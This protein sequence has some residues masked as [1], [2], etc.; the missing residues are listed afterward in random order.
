MSLDPLL[1]RDPFDQRLSE[2]GPPAVFTA[3]AAG[4][5]GLDLPRTRDAWS[6]L[7]LPPTEIE[8]CHCLFRDRATGFVQYILVTSPALLREHPRAQVRRYPDPASALQALA[9][10][11]RPPMALV[12]W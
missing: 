8:A 1:F 4:E 6:R 5:L 2:Q 9:A 3:N 12:P 7:S 11:G 10:L